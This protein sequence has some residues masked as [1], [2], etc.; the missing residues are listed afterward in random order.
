MTKHYVSSSEVPHLWAHQAQ[1]WAKGGNLSFE[2]KTL[3]SYG[4]TIGQIVDDCYGTPIA[5]ILD[6]YDSHTTRH[7]INM[8]RRAAHNVLASVT[9]ITNIHDALNHARNIALLLA[10]A[11]AKAAKALICQPENVEWKLNYAHH[12]L[13][14]A[15]DYAIAFAIAEPDTTEFDA[16]AIKALERKNRLENDTKR[17]ERNEKA[18]KRRVAH[19]IAGYRA[20]AHYSWREINRIEAVATEDDKKARNDA[21][22]AQNETAIVQWLNG[23]D[24]QLPYHYTPTDAERAEHD[25]NAIARNQERIALWR[26]GER[27]Y[28]PLSGALLRINGSEIET[29]LGARFPIEHAKKAFPLIKACHDNNKSFTPNGHAIHL[30]HYQLSS[31]DSSGNVVAGCHRVAWIEIELM[32]AQLGLE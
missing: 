20:G 28:L 16:I 29:S 5:V 8:A 18:A 19:L 11:K 12:R 25:R 14:E 1:D 17:T 4:L 15:K 31:V 6:D 32:A 23:Y 24:N 21:I 26:N 22:R 3:K 7:H 30:G 10:D 27:V 2:G 13:N 9:S